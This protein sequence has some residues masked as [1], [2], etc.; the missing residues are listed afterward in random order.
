MFPKKLRQRPERTKKEEKGR[1][2]FSN[3]TTLIPAVGL[4]EINSFSSSTTYVVVGRKKTSRKEEEE[5]GLNHRAPQR[6]PLPFCW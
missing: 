6:G 5:V 2:F 3:I 4:V 1:S